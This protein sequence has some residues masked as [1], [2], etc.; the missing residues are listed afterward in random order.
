MLKLGTGLRKSGLGLAVALRTELNCDNS[1]SNWTGE[2][3]S[4]FTNKDAGL[5]FVPSF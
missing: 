4:K 5:N 2:S 1:Y 3:G